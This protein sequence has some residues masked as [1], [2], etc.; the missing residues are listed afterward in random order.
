MS[1]SRNN[2]FHAEILPHEREL[3]GFVRR[4]VQDPDEARDLVQQCY[5]QIFAMNDHRAILAPKAF[6]FTTARNLALQ[7]IRHERVVSIELVAEMEDLNLHDDR[8]NPEHISS[9]RE[10]LRLLAQAV[11]RLP[12]QCRQVFTLRKVYGYSQKEIAAS[13]GISEHTVE[14]HIGKGVQ[15]CAD[16]LLWQAEPEHAAKPK[17]G[18]L[19]SF[20]RRNVK[21]KH[22]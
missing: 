18:G 11:E 13:L 14:K 16:Y 1:E 2:W 7:R 10:E 12:D 17:R 3:R 21:T 15:M 5:T 9:A 20:V 19:L 6:L 22:E 4:F 8:L